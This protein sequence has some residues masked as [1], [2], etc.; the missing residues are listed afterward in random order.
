[1]GIPAGQYAPSVLGIRERL[2]IHV[3]E[4][5]GETINR[6]AQLFR[7]GAVIGLMFCEIDKTASPAQYVLVNPNPFVLDL[8]DPDPCEI[9]EFLFA[10]APSFPEA[11]RPF[12]DIFEFGAMGDSQGDAWRMML[13]AW[14]EPARLKKALFGFAMSSHQR[15]W[16]CGLLADPPS[17]KLGGP[18]IKRKQNQQ[19]KTSL[20]RKRKPFSPGT[21][22]RILARDGF[23]CQSC[24]ASASEPGVKLH[25]D[26]IHPVKHGGTND[27]GNLQALCQSCNLGKGARICP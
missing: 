12:K 4:W 23:R 17:R 8:S 3:W 1:M 10:S 13:W 25:V 26:H 6:F 16:D 27:P 20:T 11:W 19:V 22:F 24:G 7:E 2:I 14:Y 5:P 9:M 18:L 21:R 15:L